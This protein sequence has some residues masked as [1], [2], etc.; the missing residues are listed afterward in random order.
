MNLINKLKTA[1]ER[2]N[3]GA[4][5]KCTYNVAGFLPLSKNMWISGYQRGYSK[6]PNKSKC[7]MKSCHVQGVSRL[8][9]EVG[10]SL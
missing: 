1:V 5:D 10:S 6:L 9:P 3:I 4:D 2:L 8:A 7:T